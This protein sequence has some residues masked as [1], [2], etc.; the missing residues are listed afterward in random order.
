VVLMGVAGGVWYVWS[1]RQANQP[2]WV[3]A[4]PKWEDGVFTD[5]APVRT[6]PA[7]RIGPN[8]KIAKTRALFGFQLHYRATRIAV[9]TRHKEVVDEIQFP[10]VAKVYRWD[11]QPGTFYY[12]IDREG[13]GAETRPEVLG[14][15]ASDIISPTP[16]PESAPLDNRVKVDGGDG[17]G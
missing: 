8:D 1:T 9:L 5:T 17:G 10:R 15:G 14:P 12:E 2:E 7:V 3:T 11:V 16:E 13:F 4:V 6:G